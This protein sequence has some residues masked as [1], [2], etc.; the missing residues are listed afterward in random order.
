MC[1]NCGGEKINVLGECID[2]TDAEGYLRETW[3]QEEKELETAIKEGYTL[4]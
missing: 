3:K 4:G 1:Q 2:C